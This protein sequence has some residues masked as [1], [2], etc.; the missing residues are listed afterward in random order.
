MELISTSAIWVS[1]SIILI[2]MLSD[3]SDILPISVSKAAILAFST[4]IAE[5]YLAI[6]N[7]SRSALISTDR[8]LV[9]SNS[10][11]SRLR[12]SGTS[13]MLCLHMF[14]PIPFPAPNVLPGGVWRLCPWPSVR[15]P[16]P[17]RMRS[18][19]NRV[20]DVLDCG[21]ITPPNVDNYG[22]GRTRAGTR[23]ADRCG[24]SRSDLDTPLAGSNWVR[25][26]KNGALYFLCP[27]L[28]SFIERSGAGKAATIC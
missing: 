13:T 19:R 27:I 12:S 20:L 6:S 2:N 4:S 7:W 11:R 21:I 24:P 22:F 23:R 5:S 3:I 1:A 16:T 26:A 18:P 8:S 25:F 10:S 17:N 15:R 28:N 14:K 9:L